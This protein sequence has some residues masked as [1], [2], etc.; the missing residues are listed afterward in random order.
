M[1]TSASRSNVLQQH[2]IRNLILG[3]LFDAIGTMSFAIPL[4]GEFSDV[5]W[6]PVSGFL[7]VWLYPGS[8]GK[9]AGIASAVEELLPFT[10]VIPTFTLM[11]FYTYVLSRPEAR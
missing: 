8:K 4:V 3:I 9:V 7:M 2:K 10:D 11:W 6:A 5:V 1:E